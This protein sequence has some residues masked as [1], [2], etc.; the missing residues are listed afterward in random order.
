MRRTGD[1]EGGE[2]DAALC[3]TVLHSSDAS[4][5]G[6]VIP[7]DAPVVIGREPSDEVALAI[8]DSH[9]SR[10]HCTFA[11]DGDG[12]KLT[13]HDSTN[14]TFVA[15]ERCKQKHLAV[16]EVARLGDTIIVV[17]RTPPSIVGVQLGTLTGRS[18][19]FLDAVIELNRVAKT[20]MPV[21]LLGE[22]G[23]GKEVFARRVH[24]A[25]GRRGP[26]LAINCA[27]I[28]EDLLE[29]SLFGHK[30]GSFTGATS[31]AAGYFGD[32]SGG[33]L[34]LDE[35]GEL[36]PNLQAKLLR[37]LE[38]GEYTSV[39]TT[40]VQRADVRIVA[41]TNAPLA[42]DMKT[43]KFRADLYARLA[44]Y[45]VSLPPLRERV[46]DI[47]ALVR[48]F[49]TQLAPERKLSC[50]AGFI[51]AA[52]LHDWPMNVRELRR[53]V[54]RVLLIAEDAT[55]LERKHLT[56]ALAQEPSRALGA[57][58]PSSVEP[59]SREELDTLLAASGG[60]VEELA[61]RFGKHRQ[62]I[63][64]WLKKHGLDPATYRKK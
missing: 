49:L 45:V 36:A 31:D 2:H 62:Q 17:T 55:L 44:G 51:E 12:A 34:F 56:K 14:G 37:V 47:P 40:T 59:P 26:F 6:A 50:S 38:T 48:A 3:L 21:L 4:V 53:V 7:L 63:Y 35:V 20:H 28:P 39:G 30:K 19:A 22:T 52:V 58:Q 54:E 15:E 13:D 29:S 23:T 5:I 27:A 46:E 57:E 16:G 32:A 41:A 1:V 9:L 33:T 42:S 10:V 61:T 11:P 18:R 64:R 43:G 8:A 60:N 24:E 25:S